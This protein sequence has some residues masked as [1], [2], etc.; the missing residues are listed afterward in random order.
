MQFGTTHDDAISFLI[1]HSQE[2]V[3]VC[4]I[5]GPFTPIS[6]WIGHGPI[7]HQIIDLNSGPIFPEALMVTGPVL[8]ITFVRDTEDRVGGIQPNTSLETTGR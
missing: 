7:D 5:L 8:L 3:W 4:L 6:L 1:Y 2:K